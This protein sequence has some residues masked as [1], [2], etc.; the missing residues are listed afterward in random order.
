MASK[1]LTVLRK[2]DNMDKE[3]E[4]GDFVKSR[5]NGFICGF[6][7]SKGKVGPIN[8][9]LVRLANGSVT[10]IAESDIKFIA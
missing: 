9:Y 1:L 2:G 10:F 7:V 6:V 5:L 8:G 4:V 3:I